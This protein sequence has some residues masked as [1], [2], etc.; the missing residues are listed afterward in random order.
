M[1]A[2]ILAAG[3]ATRLYPL[4]QD[5]PKCFLS[6]G[7]ST[8][9]ERL[10]AKLEVLHEVTEILIVTNS[11]FY[12]QFLD[13]KEKINCRLP[14]SILDDG[15]QTNETRLGAVGDLSLAIRSR[16]INS[17][18]LLL[19]SDNIFEQDL[20][21]FIAFSLKKSPA[22]TTA[23]YDLVDPK[24]A[25]G[26]FGVFEV[27]PVGKVTGMEE[28]P[29]DPLT[30]LIGVGVYF[31]PKTSLELVETYLKDPKAQDA[32][33]FFIRWLIDKSADIFAFQFKGLWYDIGDLR[34]LNEADS[35]FSKR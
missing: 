4:T 33:G 27:D 2:L 18:I 19:A 32:P 29:S 34:A 28:K 26:K 30:A 23:T 10:V 7:K 6:V 5:R 8:I 16:N 3:Y 15:T 14:I 1:K 31:F 12:P 35:I 9:L 20:A 25:A 21:E 24:L 17:D 13:W 11:K 22:I